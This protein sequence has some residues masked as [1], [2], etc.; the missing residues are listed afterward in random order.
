VRVNLKEKQSVMHYQM[1]KPMVCV[2]GPQ[3]AGSMAARRMMELHSDP[4]MEAGLISQERHQ[5]SNTNNY[6]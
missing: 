6:V 3:K 2:R 1:A 4:M 5:H